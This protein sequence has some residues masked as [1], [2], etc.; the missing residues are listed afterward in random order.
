MSLQLCEQ[1]LTGVSA[2]G[3]VNQILTDVGIEGL[4]L[5]LCEQILTGV[6]QILTGVNRY[7]QV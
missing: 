5:Q 6:N 4:D 3:C 1:I 7:S 2:T